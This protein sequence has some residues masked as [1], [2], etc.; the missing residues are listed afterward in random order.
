MCHSVYVL[1]VPSCVLIYS[2]NFSITILFST[3]S[4]IYSVHIS[5]S[6]YLRCSPICRLAQFSHMSTGPYMLFS[7][8]MLSCI[9]LF[10]AVEYTVWHVHCPVQFRKNIWEPTLKQMYHKINST[11]PASGVCCS[12]RMDGTM[13]EN[14][15]EKALRGH[16]DLD[17]LMQNNI[18]GRPVIFFLRGCRALI[19]GCPEGLCRE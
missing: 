16:R 14:E 13:M 2:L 18:C 15:R 6:V 12:L 19:R 3:F 7:L 11:V 9:L 10:G 4:C 1:H 5:C 17:G 8:Y